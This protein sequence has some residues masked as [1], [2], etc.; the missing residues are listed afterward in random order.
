MK[1]FLGFVASIVLL[2]SAAFAAHPRIEDWKSGG[3]TYTVR[4]DQG[5][6]EAIGKLSLESWNDGDN[7]SEWVVRK[8]DGTF[9]TGYTGKLEKFRISKSKPQQI[10]LVIRDSNGRFVTWE[11]MDEKLTTGWERQQNGDWR[12]VIRY[13]GKYVN[14]AQGKIETWANIGKV[15]VVRDTAD[16]QNNGQILTW[17]APE[18]INGVEKYRD[19]ATGRFIKPAGVRI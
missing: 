13:E 1:G 18:V 9:V 16:D 2:T 7:I 4:D 6:F 11:P 8:A 15:L 3:L 17:I 14:W 19:P 5:R 10:R 12:Y